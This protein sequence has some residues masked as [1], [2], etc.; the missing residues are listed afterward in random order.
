MIKPVNLP[1]QLLAARRDIGFS[2]PARR[3]H[4]RPLALASAPPAGFGATRRGRRLS[5]VQPG[6]AARHG[7]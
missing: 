1:S 6:P 7:C 2:Y 4:R 3:V 5:P